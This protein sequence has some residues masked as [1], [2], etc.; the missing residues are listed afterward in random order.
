MRKSEKIKVSVFIATSLDG[1]IARPDGDVSWL[2]DVDPFGEG[3]DGGFGQFFGSVDVL[4]M[5]RGTFEKVLEFD[6]WPYGTKPVIVLSKSLTEIPEKLRDRVRID[7]STPHDLMEKLAGEGFKKVYL[8]GGMV[9]QS[10]LREGLV[11]D[12][13]LTVIPVLIGEGVP[14]FGDLE[15]DIKLRLLETRSWENGVVQSKYQVLR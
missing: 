5:G 14:L 11:D 9:I 1:Y 10:F 8:D 6:P 13:V 4:V 12:M 7:A 15:K 3:D 2:E